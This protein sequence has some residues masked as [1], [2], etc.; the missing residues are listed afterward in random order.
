MI[1]MLNVKLLLLTESV[2]IPFQNQKLYANLAH[3]LFMLIDFFCFAN[4][5]T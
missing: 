1:M 5:I 2:S 3:C 4:P